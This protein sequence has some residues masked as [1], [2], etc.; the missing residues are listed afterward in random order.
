MERSVRASPCRRT[1]VGLAVSSGLV[2]GLILLLVGDDGDVVDDGDVGGIFA[3]ETNLELEDVPGCADV[4]REGVG[5]KG[6]FPPDT[7]P[8]NIGTTGNVFELEIRLVC[9]DP[10]YIP[11]IHDV[12]VIAYE[13]EN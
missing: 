11:V 4:E 12:S 1:T 13:Q 8:L 6:P 3:D 2:L 5:G 10:A 7:F 9:E